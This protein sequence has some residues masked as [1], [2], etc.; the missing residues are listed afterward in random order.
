[1]RAIVNNLEPF[2]VPIQRLPSLRDL[3]DGKVS[4]GQIRTLSIEDLLERAPVALDRNVTR[5]L[6]EGRDVFVT[7]AGGFIGRELCRQI[8]ALA[9]RRLTLLDRYE[10]GLYATLNDLEEVSRGTQIDSEVADVT[11]ADRLRQIMSVAKPQVE[12]SP[13]C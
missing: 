10:N 8:L 4:V 6:I 7:G 2:K 11:R 13:T 12:R 5:E 1:M 9:P 3:L